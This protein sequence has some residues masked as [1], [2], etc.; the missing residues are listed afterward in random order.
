L[1]SHPTPKKN[2]QS[3]VLNL[4]IDDTTGSGSFSVPTLYTRTTGT[5]EKHLQLFTVQLNE[6]SQE[7]FIQTSMGLLNKIREIHPK[8]NIL[9]TLSYWNGLQRRRY[10]DNEYGHTVRGGQLGISKTDALNKHEVIMTLVGKYYNRDWEYDEDFH[11]ELENF[12]EDALRFHACLNGLDES[13]VKEAQRKKRGGLR[14]RSIGDS[15]AGGS[16]TSGSRFTNSSTAGS[17]EDWMGKKVL[18]KV[19]EKITR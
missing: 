19:L 18:C 7:F 10:N 14:L 11:T 17:H 5:V 1:L 12:V 13:E 6:P 8:T 16:S 4:V 9:R 2:E 15:V 3:P